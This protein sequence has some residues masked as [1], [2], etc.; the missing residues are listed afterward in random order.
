MGSKGK[1]DREV[2]WSKYEPPRVAP[3]VRNDGPPR[4][5]VR[6]PAPLALLGASLSVGA[7]V[8]A[9]TALSLAGVALDPLRV[10]TGL[11]LTFLV[12]YTSIGFLAW[13]VLLVLE[14]E[15]GESS[16]GNAAD[17][18]TSEIGKDTS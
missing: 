11:A 10:I 14:R 5:L 2:R 9:L 16:R 7:A 3:F 13:Y 17:G 12:A 18:K 4:Q 6:E 1:R 15:A 8:L